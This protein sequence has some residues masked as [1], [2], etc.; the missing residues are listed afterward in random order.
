MLAPQGNRVEGLL[1]ADVGPETDPVHFRPIDDQVPTQ[2][3]IEIIDRLRELVGDLVE[4]VE[5][6]DV[7]VG[8]GIGGLDEIDE[9]APDQAEG[10]T[11]EQVVLRELVD[12]DDSCAEFVELIFDGFTVCHENTFH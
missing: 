4:P 5:V 1:T 6:V 2:V 12:F 8:V 3:R 9:H 10:F 7:V 11:G